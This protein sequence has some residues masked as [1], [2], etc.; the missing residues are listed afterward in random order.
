MLS[1]KNLIFITALVFIWI[2]GCQDGSN[3]IENLT[4]TT[5]APAENP[6]NGLAKATTVM[7]KDTINEY[8]QLSGECLGELLDIYYSDE[9]I[10]IPRSI[11]KVD[12]IRLC[13]GVRLTRSLMG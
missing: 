8:W 7:T 1:S 5:T 13:I 12:F 2:S 11:I 10:C 3:P 4:S 6:I 9:L